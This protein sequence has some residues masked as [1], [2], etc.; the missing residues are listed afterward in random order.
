MK[1]K[2]RITALM[3]ALALT[4]SGCGADIGE[5]DSEQAA[6]DYSNTAITGQVTAIDGTEVTLQLGELTEAKEGSEPPQMPEG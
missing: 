4:L 3:A 5:E 1:G 2:I 6:S